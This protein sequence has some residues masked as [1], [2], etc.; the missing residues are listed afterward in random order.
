LSALKDDIEPLYDELEK[1]ML[2][3]FAEYLSRHTNQTWLHWN[4]RDQNYGFQAIEHRHR[5]LKGEPHSVPDDRKVD[6]SRLLISMYG[7]NYIQHPRLEKLLELNDIKAKDFLS[8]AEE[9]CAFE[10]R[11]YVDLHRSTLRKV[12]VL[13]NIAQ[14]AYDGKLKTDST[15]G[16]SHGMSMESLLAIVQ[17]HPVYIFFVVLA[18]AG[19]VLGLVQFL[20]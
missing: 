12:D 18:T 4:M 6:L 11:R 5:V 17:E 9:A 8:G 2:D 10:E 20:L 15:W 14:R 19:G 1:E 13:S 3:S 16:Q 7:V